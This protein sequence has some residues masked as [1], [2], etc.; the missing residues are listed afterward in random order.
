MLI[1]FLIGQIPLT[2]STS[3]IM[4]PVP[5]IREA[6]PLAVRIL[7]PAP[8]PLRDTEASQP[9]SPAGTGRTARIELTPPINSPARLERIRWLMNAVRAFDAGQYRQDEA[10]ADRLLKNDPRDTM[11]LTIAGAARL[12]LSDPAGAIERFQNYVKHH[13]LE[14]MGHFYLGLARHLADDRPGAIE[15]YW[16]ALLLDS[17]LEA[18]RANMNLLMAR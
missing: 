1:P 3:E 7:P 8:T 12:R 4:A 16:T 11:A 10:A 2:A 9:D 15:S 13:P 17:S 14:A 5:V 6:E 18:A